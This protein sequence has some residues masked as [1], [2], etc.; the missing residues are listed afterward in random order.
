MNCEKSAE[1]I[2]VKKFQIKMPED[3][4]N[5]VSTAVFRQPVF[6]MKNIIYASINEGGA[7]ITEKMIYICGEIIHM[8]NW[9]MERKMVG[10]L[11]ILIK[12][13]GLN[14]KK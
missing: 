10:I 7:V 9:E 3:K 13:V 8:D 14:L 6:I 12:N 5:N 2:V 4:R 1:P 11:E